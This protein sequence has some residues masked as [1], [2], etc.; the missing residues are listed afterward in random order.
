MFRIDKDDNSIRPLKA[1]SFSELGFKER[2]HLQCPSSNKMGLQ[3]GLSIGGSGSFVQ[4]I[5]PLVFDVASDAV[6]LCAF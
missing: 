6:V 5:M 1:R 3:N 2:Q 4:M